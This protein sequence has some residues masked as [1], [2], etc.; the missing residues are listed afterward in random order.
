[1]EGWRFHER[2][3]VE[4]RV[5]GEAAQAL[6]E[7]VDKVMAVVPTADMETCTGRIARLIA[8]LE[9]GAA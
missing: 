4:K 9:N 7:V 3:A 5:H 2:R 6:S 8:D 1:M